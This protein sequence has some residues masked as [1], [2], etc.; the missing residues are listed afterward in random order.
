MP[1]PCH[2]YLTTKGKNDED[3]NQ[4]LFEQKLR[5]SLNLVEYIV[6]DTPGYHSLLSKLAMMISSIRPLMIVIWI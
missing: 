3:A 5:D 2:F 1:Q 4:L 6:I